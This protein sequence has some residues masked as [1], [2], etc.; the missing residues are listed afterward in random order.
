MG[1]KPGK[2]RSDRVKE[3]EAA[4][5]KRWSRLGTNERQSYWNKTELKSRGWTDTL[6][7]NFLSEP[8][9][10]IVNMKRKAYPIQ[11]YLKE[12]V[13]RIEASV[14][15]KSVQAKS[16][17]RSNTA[18]LAI[19]ARMETLRKQIEDLQIEVPALDFD[20]LIQRACS[21]HR[22]FNADKPNK[23]RFTRDSD[24]D[25]LHRIC[26]NYLR[27]QLTK[28]DNLLDEVSGK[29][30]ADDL[31]AMIREKVLDAIEVTYP[32]LG[33]ACHAQ[34]VRYDEEHLGN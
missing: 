25:S 26:V 28:Y 22:S 31:R 5:E 30:G 4:P 8:D 14:A 2:V 20:V 21:E 1:R 16:K 23:Q 15:F 17:R 34:R 13:E 12:R 9:E 6:V 18:T 11:L 19:N 7:S 33:E 24:E 3:P 29:P 27:H 32:D 10:T